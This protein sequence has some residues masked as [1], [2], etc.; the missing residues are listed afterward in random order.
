MGQLEKVTVDIDISKYPK[1]QEALKELRTT[2]NDGEVDLLRLKNQAIEVQA[3]VQAGWA[4]VFKMCQDEGLISK[5]AN[6][7]D[8][9]MEHKRARGVL[10]I[11]PED[12]E[13]RSMK[14]I[15]KQIKIDLREALGG[16]I[17][18]DD[19]SGPVVH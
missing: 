18:G 5:D 12:D 14:G 11:R 19:D 7:D 1:I 4:N 9:Q 13:P 16:Q 2:Q 15:L 17:P 6:Y 8:H 10:A 3:R